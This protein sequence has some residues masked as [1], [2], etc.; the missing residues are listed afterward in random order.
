VG[1]KEEWNR[2]REVGD[3]ENG[4][5][6]KGRRRRRMERKKEGMERWEKEGEM[7]GRVGGREGRWYE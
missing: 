6:C 7:E 3:G 2:W 4:E 5:R 1:G